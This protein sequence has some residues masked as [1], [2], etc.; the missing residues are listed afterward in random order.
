M[1]VQRKYVCRILD[2]GKKSSLSEKT[3][4]EKREESKMARSPKKIGKRAPKKPRRKSRKRSS[5]NAS[6]GDQYTLSILDGEM[7]NIFREALLKRP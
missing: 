4:R 1:G 5:P 6:A 7:K 2:T 3:N